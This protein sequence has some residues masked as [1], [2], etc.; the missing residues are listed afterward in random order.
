MNASKKRKADADDIDLENGG[1][2]S[3]SQNL[4]N[5]NSKGSKSVTTPDSSSRNSLSKHGHASVEG[6][7]G[8]SKRLQT[9]G[10]G[11]AVE[12]RATKSTEAIPAKPKY[13]IK[14][15]VPPRPFPTVPTSVSATGPRSTHSEG[16]NLI[17]ITRKTP[18]A[19]YLR[20]CKDVILKDGYASLAFIYIDL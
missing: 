15:L 13:K 3:R 19:A 2:D 5:R 17:C 8:S 10:K 11:K 6:S 9:K 20:R 18:L 14:K 4:P 16:K 1:N 7:S 12:N